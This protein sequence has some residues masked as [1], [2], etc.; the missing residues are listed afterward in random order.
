MDIGK[1]IQ[2]LQCAGCHQKMNTPHKKDCEFITDSGIVEDTPLEFEFVPVAQRTRAVG[3][4][5]TGR[6]FESPQ[7]LYEK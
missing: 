6:E 1:T 5:P 3:F 7:E 2:T 4:Y